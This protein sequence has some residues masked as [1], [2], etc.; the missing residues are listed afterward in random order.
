MTIHGLRATGENNADDIIYLYTTDEEAVFGTTNN[1]TRAIHFHGMVRTTSGNGGAFRLRWAKYNASGS[2]TMNANSFMY[3]RR[4]SEE[5][6]SELQSRE[7][8]VCRLLLEKK[9]QHQHLYD[10]LSVRM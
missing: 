5:H 7:N 8:I 6:T 3:A 4:R 2:L 9:N 1:E 10:L